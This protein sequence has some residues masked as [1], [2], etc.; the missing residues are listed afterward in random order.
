MSDKEDLVA[1]Y[2]YG[3]EYVTDY[4]QF[5]RQVLDK[6]II[7]HQVEVQPASPSKEIC[8]LKCPWCYGLSATDTGERLPP[9][10]ATEIMSS[11]LFP[12]NP[13]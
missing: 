3:A 13:I 4:A 11:G 12:S 6:T 2:Q 9:E 10:R 1:R 5:R 7:P 8:W